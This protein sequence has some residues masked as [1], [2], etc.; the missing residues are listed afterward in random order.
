MDGAA[1]RTSIHFK[2]MTFHDEPVTT[3]LL[4]QLVE[5][6]S[7]RAQSDKPLACART[8][9]KIKYNP[10]DASSVSVWN[11]AGTP[12]HYVTLRKVDADYASGLSYWHR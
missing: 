3:Y 10:V 9:V 4:Q 11:R 5:Y 12:P 1:R 6:E 7:K 8:R 2:N